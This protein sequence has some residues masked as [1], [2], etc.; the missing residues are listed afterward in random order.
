M[1]AASMKKTESLNHET[2]ESVRADHLERRKRKTKR[3]RVGKV[4]EEGAGLNRL[5]KT[6]RRSQLVAVEM[7][8]ASQRVRERSRKS[9]IEERE[10]G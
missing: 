9:L 5:L 10:E 1:S 3:R 8:L 4:T 6:L 7:S 2:S